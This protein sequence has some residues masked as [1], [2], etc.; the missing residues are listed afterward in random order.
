MPEIWFF[1]CQVT[2]LGSFPFKLTT[3]KRIKEN[4]RSVGATR[5]DKASY[6]SALIHTF[7][8]HFAVDNHVISTRLN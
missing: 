2:T 7:I 3:W 5:T 8:L 1:V 4:I 6:S